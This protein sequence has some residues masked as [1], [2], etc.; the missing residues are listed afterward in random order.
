VPGIWT[1]EQILGWKA[2]TDAV[3]A[4]GCY[5]FCQLWNLG[6]AGSTESLGPLGYQ[7]KS[8]SALPI[9]DSKPVPE[10]MTDAD[11]LVT[12]QDYASAA[13]NAMEAGFDGVEIHGANGYLLDQFLQDTCNKRTDRWGGSVENRARFPLEVTKAVIAAVG[14]TRTAL[15]LSPFSDYLGMLMDD[16]APT[17]LYLIQ[18]LKSLGL[19]Y[20]HLIEARISGNDDTDCGGSNDVS[21]LVKEWDNASPI[22]IAGGFN[23]DSAK[24]AVDEIFE[25]YDV[26]IAFG[27]YYVANPD[28]AF[29]LR[30][31]LKLERYE[32]TYFYTPKTATGYV[33]YPFSK[34][35]LAAKQ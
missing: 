13:K 26:A 29:R 21:F 28:L 6:R 16:P 17:F 23:A 14:A 22:V 30:E 35:Y 24:R 25:D 7:L 10:E 3:H 4:R 19:A 2:V 1:K 8:S 27:R 33:D 20:L 11:I 31:G 34:E 12:I 15:R 9:D 5:I 18:Q 32:R